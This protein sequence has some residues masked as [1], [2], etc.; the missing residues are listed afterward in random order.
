M[1]VCL[2]CLAGGEL[3]F[4]LPYP[5]FVHHKTTIGVW[6]QWSSCA[7]NQLVLS[8]ACDLLCSIRCPKQMIS[9]RGLIK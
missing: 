4:D 1:E 5:D 8:S 9:V 6:R 7:F 3:Q 2:E